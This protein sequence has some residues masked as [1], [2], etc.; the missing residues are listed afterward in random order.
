MAHRAPS[1]TTPTA[2]VSGGSGAALIDVRKR[3]QRDIV[4]AIWTL[5]C[6]IRFAVGLNVSLALAAMLGTLI[7]QMPPGI[8]DFPSEVSRFLTDAQGRYADLSNV[9]FWAGFYQLY[10]S[11]WFRMLIALTVFGIVVCTLN[12]WRPIM[13][14][15]SQ[16]QVRVSDAFIEGMSERASFRSVPLSVERAGELVG[17]ALRKSRYRVLSEATAKGDGLHLYADRDRWSKLITFVSHGALVM[18]ILTVAG[19][20]NAGWREPSLFFYPGQ[21]VNVGHDTNFSV[22]NDGFTI[23][24]YEGTTSIKEF[25]NSLSVI[26]AGKVVLTKTIIV[27]DPLN[28]QGINF[29]LVSYEPVVFASGLQPSGEKIAF[30]EMGASGPAPAA[31]A[32]D[33]AL[34]RFQSLSSDNLPLDFLQFSVPEHTI[35]LEMTYYKDILRNPG[36]NPPLYLRAFVD[37]NFEKPIYDDFIARQ[38]P[39]TLPGY[40]GYKLSFVGNTATVLEVA[41]DPGLGLLAFFFTVMAAGFTTSLYITFTRCW[42][43]ITPSEE[44]PGS[45]N[46]VVAG[47]AEKNKVSFERDFERLAG[48]I[49]DN[50]ASG[51]AAEQ[52][53]AEPS[54]A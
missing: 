51:T 39:L 10:D 5:F 4:E 2:R 7:P 28:Y 50:L 6:S 44:R 40:E 30:K 29:F 12:R 31:T 24:Y 49:R 53:T 37:K 33:A 47:L 22:R 48:R 8:Q 54:L 3:P 34:V 27:N 14:L 11:L 13:R 35:T 45:V 43:R 26:E 15:I 46:I 18:F 19:L 9:L 52:A 16:P 23:E 42:A 21:P 36:E 41:K 17:S 20:A 1:P 32:D 38:G 25:R